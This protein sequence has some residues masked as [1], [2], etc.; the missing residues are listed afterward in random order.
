[1]WKKL[2]FIFLV[3]FWPCSWSVPA[4][5]AGPWFLISESELQIIEAYKKQ[6]EAERQNWLSQVNEL[7]T[8]ATR[9]N[10]RAANSRLQSEN[11][12][13]LLQQERE[14]N[15]KLT[16][17]FN[18]YEIAASQTISQKDTCIGILESKNEKLVYQRNTL[19]AIVITAVSVALLFVAFKV[20]RF[21]KVLPF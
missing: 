8:Q 15:Q 7:K 2:L 10:E 3:F 20:L 18:E 19:L 5:D 11:L 14:A 13:Q 12:N 9:L 16:L 17:S 1:M 21:F 6:L 4:Q